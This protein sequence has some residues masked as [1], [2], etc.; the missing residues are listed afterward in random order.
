[1][2]TASCSAIANFHMAVPF[3]KRKRSIFEYHSRHHRMFLTHW[4]TK[5][6]RGDFPRHN[7]H[8]P[9][10]NQF[11]NSIIP[12]ERYGFEVRKPRRDYMKIRYRA[13]DVSLLGGKQIS[14]KSLVRLGNKQNPPDLQRQMFPLL[15]LVYIV[16]VKVFKKTTPNGELTQQPISLLVKSHPL[17]RI[18][19]GDIML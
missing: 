18:T 4:A 11:Y 8:N 14:A 16:A 12:L 13:G 1:M 2:I 5:N 6:A 17:R 19:L 15:F 9:L 3:W 7:S 10:K